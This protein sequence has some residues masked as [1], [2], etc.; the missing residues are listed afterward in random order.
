MRLHVRRR[1]ELPAFTPSFLL[2]AAWKYG[3]GLGVAAAVLTAGGVDRV[4]PNGHALALNVLPT[5][6]PCG[7]IATDAGDP[8]T[9]TWT[10]VS[11]P[12]GTGSTYNLPVT[13][14]CKVPSC[15]RTVTSDPISTPSVD[16]TTR[17]SGV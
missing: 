8:H 6:V 15:K 1:L 5:N 14:A 12:Y 10:A 3:V 2:R 16:R 11:S 13:F 17:P 7:P 9:A 4:Q